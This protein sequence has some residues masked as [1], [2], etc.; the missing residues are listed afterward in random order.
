MLTD[1]SIPSITEKVR[2]ATEKVDAQLREC[3]E[4]PDTDI[5]NVVMQ[6]LAQFSSDVRS[7]MNG[8][9]I[10]LGGEET[11]SFQ[12][13]WADLADHFRDVVLF[14]KPR[15]VVKHESDNVI[16]N[17]VVDLISDDEESLP[18]T[19]NRKRQRVSES[20]TPGPAPKRIIQTDQTGNTVKRGETMQ[21]PFQPPIQPQMQPPM[22]RGPSRVSTSHNP[23]SHTPFAR[24]ALLGKGFVGLSDIRQYIAKH[25]S[26]GQPGLVHPKTQNELCL[27]SINPWSQV[28]EIFMAQTFSIVRE[29]LLLI[30][31]KNLGIYEQTEL[32]KAAS[33]L[34]GRF[35]DGFQREQETAL[36]QLYEVENYKSFTINQ[37]SIA[38]HKAKE[39]EA[40]TLARRQVRARAVVDQQMRLDPKKKLPADL[41]KEERNKILN[42]RMAEVKDEQLGPDPFRLE[43]DVAAY[44][45]G[46]YMTAAFRFVDSVCLS[47]QAK[48]FREIRENI[49]FHLEKELGITTPRDGKHLFHRHDFT[50]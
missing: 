23:F 35:L 48:F 41:T 33:E 50:C 30:L 38:D 29:Q 16:Q 49:L 47:V 22:A 18:A 1:S 12:S 26:A 13:P 36:R 14:I 46:Y 24:L 31:H 27:Q 19:P 4:V 9:A 44:V 8:E 32:Y 21:P 6:H 20:P 25:K 40:L 5:R 7:V 39:L 15:I 42:K 11:A 10:E 34:L 45:R 28:L 37:T 2:I 3:P 17:V 43:L